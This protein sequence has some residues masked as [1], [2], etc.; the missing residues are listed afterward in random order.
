MFV[1]G[2]AVKVVPKFIEK[3]FGKKKFDEWLD[4]LPLKSKEIFN[5]FILV[6][7]WYPFKEAYLIPTKKI[8][9]MFFKGDPKG[10][11]NLGKFSSDYVLRG[12]Y[13][14]YANKVSSEKLADRSARILSTYFKPSKIKAIALTEN[15]IEL[16]LIEFLEFN[17]YA[18]NR[19]L[20][21]V[22]GALEISGYKNIKLDAKKT[23]EK[24][25]LVIKIIISWD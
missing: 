5:S 12:I 2:S 16:K 1:K 21:W 11:W 18:E 19:L 24:P 22:E 8:C 23:L 10:A 15:K 9:K 7:R 17:K 3:K 13:R 14:I 6:N 20:G 25:G 4:I